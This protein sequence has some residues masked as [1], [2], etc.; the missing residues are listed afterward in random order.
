MLAVHLY[1]WPAMT[2]RYGDSTVRLTVEQ[3]V[4]FPNIPDG[5]LDAMMQVLLSFPLLPRTAYHLATTATNTETAEMAAE[6]L[7]SWAQ[8]QIGIKIES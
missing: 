3:N 2:C 4:L 7:A 5:H 1:V 8:A 6:L